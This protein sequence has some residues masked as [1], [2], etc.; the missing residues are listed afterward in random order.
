MTLPRATA[1]ACCLA[2]FCLL[3]VP[4]LAGIA[5][6]TAEPEIRVLLDDADKSQVVAGALEWSNESGESGRTDNEATVEL[7]INQRSLG[8]V[9]AKPS[10]PPVRKVTPS[11][12]T[13]GLGAA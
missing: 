13:A 8:L 1:H 6:A 3:L 4:L 7:P 5:R 9:L 2:P 12:Q 10:P 11:P